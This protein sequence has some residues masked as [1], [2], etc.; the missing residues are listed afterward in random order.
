MFHLLKKIVKNLLKKKFNI[1]KN[2]GENWNLGFSSTYDFSDKNS[3]K[4]AEEITLNYIDKYM[5][6]N[7]LSVSL[8]Y[9]NNSASSD[10]DIKSEN[11][12]FLNFNFRNFFC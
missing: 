12:I 1:N 6:Q 4:I 3:D 11:S 5:L 2:Y 8:T 7:C 10:R 9:K